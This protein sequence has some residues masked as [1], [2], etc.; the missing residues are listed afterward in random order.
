MPS[1][2]EL[3]AA[4]GEAGAARKALVKEWGSW[5]NVFCDALLLRLP[6]IKESVK[7]HL[8]LKTDGCTQVNIDMGVTGAYTVD[9]TDDP[10]KVIGARLN[11]QLV[12]DTNSSED[13]ANS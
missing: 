12:C 13:G 10:F 8:W 1:T 5:A 2:N 11:D 3:R 7:I 9:V 6:D 4:L